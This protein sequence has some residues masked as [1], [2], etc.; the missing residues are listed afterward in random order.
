MPGGPTRDKVPTPSLPLC[1]VASLTLG[2]RLLPQ[3]YRSQE[4]WAKAPPCKGW[5]QRRFTSCHQSS[6]A[7]HK[8]T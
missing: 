2:Q 5:V 8:L 4:N 3:P 1:Q 6:M 7:F